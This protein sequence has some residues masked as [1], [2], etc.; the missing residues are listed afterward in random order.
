MNN[1]NHEDIRKKM[2][3]KWPLLS[4]VECCPL[5]MPLDCLQHCKGYLGMTSHTGA[6]ADLSKLNGSVLLQ[7]EDCQLARK[8]LR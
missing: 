2:E 8:S 6:C 5:H 1:G 4:G 3:S 7:L